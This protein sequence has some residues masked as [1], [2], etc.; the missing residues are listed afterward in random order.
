MSYG[1][2]VNDQP[3]SANGIN[4]HQSA[5]GTCSACPLSSMIVA[6]AIVLVDRQSRIKRL[7]RKLSPSTGADGASELADRGHHGALEVMKVRT[8]ADSLGRLVFVYQ[9]SSYSSG[10]A[11]SPAS[12]SVL[13]VELFLL[14][15]ATKCITRSKPGI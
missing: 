6:Q 2:K 9:L 8:I 1:N 14:V 10:T 11:H 7:T 15:C 12:M 3:P 4:R 13:I 5:N